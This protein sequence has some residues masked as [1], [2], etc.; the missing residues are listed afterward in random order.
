[1]KDQEE[2]IKNLMSANN[3]LHNDIIN[4]DS[5]SEEELVSISE[6]MKTLID[7]LNFW[8]E[9]DNSERFVYELK[10]HIQWMLDTF[11]E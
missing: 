4:N 7:Q 10:N 1:M 5:F 11:G 3:L 6:R 8:V 2:Y 9:E